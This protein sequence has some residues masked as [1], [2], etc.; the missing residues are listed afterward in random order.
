MSAQVVRL[1]QGAWSGAAAPVPRALLDQLHDLLQLDPIAGASAVRTLFVA[2]EAGKARLARHLAPGEQDQ[3]PA[4]PAFAIIG[5]DFQFAVSLIL[6]AS[7]SAN[8]DRGA[9]VRTAQRSAALQ[10]DTLRLAAAAVG[11]RA[12]AIANFDATGLRSEFFAATQATVVCLCRLAP[13][14]PLIAASA[15]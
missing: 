6:S 5:F 4:A 7:A 1:R 14:A 3:A 8:P 2:S 12:S 11:L 10:G 15:F 13:E 9:A